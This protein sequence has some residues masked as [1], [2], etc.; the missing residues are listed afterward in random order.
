MEKSRISRR[1]L[2]VS[3]ASL[4]LDG[5][6]L[7]QPAAN[8][9]NWPNR[10]IKIVVPG[11]AGVGGDIFARMLAA[12]LQDALRQSVVIENKAGANGIIGNDAVAKSAPL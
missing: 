3:T 9:S 6:A 10:P 8:V 7:A 12:P 1:T 5:L 11:P 2:L 4:A